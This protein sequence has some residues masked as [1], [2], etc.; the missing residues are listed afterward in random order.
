M[1][2]LLSQI[3]KSGRKGQKQASHLSVCCS[4]HFDTSF[5]APMAHEGLL[6]KHTA[7]SSC[8]VGKRVCVRVCARACPPGTGDLTLSLI[9]SQMSSVLLRAGWNFPVKGHLKADAQATTFSSSILPGPLLPQISG[10]HTGPHIK[11]RNVNQEKATSTAGEASFLQEDPSSP[12]AG[13]GAQPR[14]PWGRTGEGW[15]KRI[16]DLKAESTASLR[17]H[18]SRGKKPFEAKLMDR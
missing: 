17:S 5:P 4:P 15:T 2:I 6:S 8:Q 9:N 16:R 7:H 10:L 12:E 14:D 3:G 18:T 11:P 13:G 1:P